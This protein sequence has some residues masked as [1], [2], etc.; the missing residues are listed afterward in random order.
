MYR[1]SWM[2]CWAT[3][4]GASVAMV[5]TWPG[6][7]KCWLSD[8]FQS[9]CVRFFPGTPERGT[10]ISLSWPPWCWHAMLFLKDG[11][12]STA[13]LPRWHLNP[14]QILSV[15]FKPALSLLTPRSSSLK[16]CVISSHSRLARTLCLV[17]LPF[18]DLC[19]C[20]AV[21]T[22]PTPCLLQSISLLLCLG[23]VVGVFIPSV[24]LPLY[25]GAVDYPVTKWFHSAVCGLSLNRSQGFLNCPRSRHCGAWNRIKLKKAHRSCMPV[26]MIAP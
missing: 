16:T 5:T 6:S 15:T 3:M 1:L 19:F 17:C 14:V 23:S 8:S 18:P 4:A 20:T 22:S 24:A 26:M 13:S 11:F 2:L 12:C 7:L 9:K 10:H 25:C 21:V